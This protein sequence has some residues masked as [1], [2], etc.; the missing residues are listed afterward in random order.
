MRR[1]F[2]WILSIVSSVAVIAL[3]LIQLMWVRDAFRVQEQQFNLL[4][5]KSL[6]QITSRLE[7]KETY[8]QIQGELVRSGDSLGLRR[9][10]LPK[11]LSASDDNQVYDSPEINQSYYSF[12][13]QNPG[14]I[15]TQVDLISGDTAI[16]VP[17]NSLYQNDIQGRQPGRTR[18]RNETDPNYSLLL[19]NKKV[20]VEK[21]INQIMQN[22]GRIEERLSYPTLDSLI[23][24]EFDEK[25]ITLPY[26]FAVRT[27]NVRYTLHSAGFNP[28]VKFQKYK[29]LLFPHDVRTS[30]NFLVVYFPARQ[31]YL[32]R[33]VGTMAGASLTLA[34][35]IL[36]ISSVAIYVI[37][38]QKRLSEIKNDFVNNMTHE[39]KTPISTISLAS[40]MLADKSLGSDAKNLEHISSLIQEESKRL[41]NQVERVLQ[42]SILEEGRMSLRIQ[43]VH[44]DQLVRQATEKISLQIGKKNGSIHLDLDS[45]NN[46]IEGDETH[47]T[48]VIFNL[49]DNAMKYCQKEPV[50]RIT[51]RSTSRAIQVIISDNGIG[52]GKEYLNK[53]FDKFFRVPTGNIHDVKGFGLGLSYVRKVIEQHHGTI[54]VASEPGNGTAFTLIIPKRQKS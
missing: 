10:N 53:I 47:L 54:S 31:D 35:I 45:G 44:F 48:N 33:S 27:G 12:Q 24:E 37:F 29:S 23:R 9:L 41:G 40:Q 26:E 13:D 5:N 25:G 36:I 39:L 30:P 14:N 3:I 18:S 8:D 1:T 22:E 46:P 34:L 51:S 4:I 16:S 49:I 20:Y 38:R 17:G 32:F 11:T 52:I 42:M 19:T 50:I 43:P 21:V 15:E 2:I 6:A 7:L 28:M